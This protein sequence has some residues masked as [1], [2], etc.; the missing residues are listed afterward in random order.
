[1]H[2]SN[3]VILTFVIFN[4]NLTFGTGGKDK[5]GVAIAGWGYY[6]V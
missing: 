1:M 2:L 4:S 5:N 6:E 3:R